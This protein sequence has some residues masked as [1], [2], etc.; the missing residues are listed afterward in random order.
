MPKA[1]GITNYKLRMTEQDPAGGRGVGAASPVG[2][3]T[4]RGASMMRSRN[5]LW[6]VCGLV[7]AGFGDAM[8]VRGADLAVISVSPGRHALN[9]PRDS[10]IVVEFDKAVKPESVVPVR[11]FWAFGRWSGTVAGT[12]GFSNEDR[13]VTLTPNQPFSAGEPVMVILSHDLEATDGTK[14]RAAGYSYQFWTRARPT[15][16]DF[17]QIAVMSTRAAGE[18]QTTAYGGIASDLDGDRFLDLTIVNEETADLRVFLNRA[19]HTGL[20]HDFIQPTF[21]VGFHASP[22]EPSDFDRDGIV[23]ICV[24]NILDSSVSI[25]LG[26]GDG[27]FAPQ[28]KIT[29]G[30]RPRGIAVLDLDGDGDVDIANTNYVS[31]SGDVS[32]L[33][34]DGSGVFGAPTFFEAGANGEWALGAAD[35]NDDGILDLV[36]GAQTAQRVVVQLGTGAGSFTFASSQNSDGNVW[37]LNTG[38]LDGNGTEDVAVGNSGSNRAAILLGDGAGNLGLPQRYLTD[39]F[40]IATDLG[41]LDG[42]GDLDWVTSSYSG[43]WWVFTNDGDGTFTFS[44]EFNSS[45]AA[46]CAIML[47]FDNDGDL[48]LALIDEEDDQVIL[49]KN[50]GTTLIP[51]VSAW[52]LAALGLSLLA[53]GTIITFRRRPQGPPSSPQRSRALGLTARG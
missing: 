4:H 29:V 18:T 27:T 42:D 46:S 24:A 26:N 5:S 38:D 44:R 2:Y 30:L 19:D 34:N 17:T 3:N 45:I 35:M 43:D 49:M 16:M 37:M 15:P 41:D 53:A 50:S 36:V 12:F 7:G 52:G 14:L 32:L 31:T 20:Y 13:T 9:V 10:R 51:T 21:A 28:Q 11:S 25:L 6:I 22:S 33:V 8:T 39:P 40:T 23:D 47:D 48:D 1:K